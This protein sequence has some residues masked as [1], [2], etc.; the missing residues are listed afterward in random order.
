MDNGGNASRDFIYV[1]DMVRG[2][3]ACAINGKSG[4]SYNLASGVETT[5]LELAHL[6]NKATGNNTPLDLRPA[7]NWDRSGKRFASTAKAAEDL[8]FEANF[9]ISTGIRKTVDWT[10]KN[11]E[12]INSNIN[13]H[14]LFL[15]QSKS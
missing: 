14:S 1:D 2:L 3:K 10:K 5:I 8:G 15:E 9:E 4:E 12:L 7:R 11:R 6:I 13:K